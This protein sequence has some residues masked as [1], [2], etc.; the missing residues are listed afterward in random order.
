MQIWRENKRR[1]PPS[2]RMRVCLRIASSSISSNMASPVPEIWLCA[3]LISIKSVHFAGSRVAEDIDWGQRARVAGCTFLYVPEMI[4]FH[5]ARQS[6]RELFVKWDRHIQ[7]AVNTGDAK[8]NVESSL[9]SSC[10]CSSDFACFRLD[11]GHRQRSDPWGVGAHQSNIR[12][13][14]GTRISRL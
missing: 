7:H 2:R 3:A 4:V 14:N 13:R 1:L 8:R 6:L 10:L 9:D 5:P 12:S 11:Q